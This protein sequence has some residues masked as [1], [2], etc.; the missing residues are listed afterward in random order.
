MSGS[1]AQAR[2]EVR[3]TGIGMPPDVVPH[4]FERFY[5][6]DPSRSSEREGAGLGLSLVK[7][8]ADRHDG[9][10]PGRQRARAGLD[11]PDRH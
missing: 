3:D 7:W 5:R 1:G 10:D 11:L 8:I 6:A 4:V 9:D 2:L